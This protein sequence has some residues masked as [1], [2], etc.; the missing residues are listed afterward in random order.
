MKNL[1]IT[2][3]QHERLKAGAEKE[4]IPLASFVNAVLD[5]S[6]SKFEAGIISVPAPKPPIA[7]EVAL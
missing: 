2:D 6:L 1:K 5:F 4:G 3:Y 7:E